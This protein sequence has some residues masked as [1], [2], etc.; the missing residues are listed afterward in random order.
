MVSIGFFDPREPISF[1]DPMRYQQP[2][3][4]TD[5]FYSPRRFIEHLKQLALTY[6]PL[7]IRDHLPRHLRGKAATWYPIWHAG[8][9]DLHKA[10]FEICRLETITDIISNEFHH[11]DDKW[12]EYDYTVKKYE[13]QPRPIQQKPA[14]RPTHYE[15]APMRPP[16]NPPLQTYKKRH[17]DCSQP[18]PA[19][20]FAEQEYGYSYDEPPP[21]IKHPV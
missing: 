4:E 20:Y 15:P 8:L 1:K 2:E 12:R 5:V 21:A 14:S 13:V 9:S 10:G 11:I 6:N 16:I 3:A 19:A 18:H 17:F 7:A